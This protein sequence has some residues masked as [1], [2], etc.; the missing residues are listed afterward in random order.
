MDDRPQGWWRGAE[1]FAKLKSERGEL[2]LGGIR[3]DMITSR[4]IVASAGRVSGFPAADSEVAWS[5]PARPPSNVVMFALFP[6]P[7]SISSAIIHRG[8]IVQ[9]FG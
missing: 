7:L 8:I 3:T 1:G 2:R 9:A 4:Q 5:P 6:Y